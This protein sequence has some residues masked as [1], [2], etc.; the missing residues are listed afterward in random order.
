MFIQPEDEFMRN[1]LVV[2]ILMIFCITA[3]E[4]PFSSRKP[5]FPNTSQSL[6]F[7]P[8]TPEEVLTNLNYAIQE[9]NSE[10]YMRCFLNEPESQRSFRFIPDP[11]GAALYPHLVQWTWN[12]E[13]TMIQETFSLVPEDSSILLQFTENI[14]DVIAADSA[15]LVRQYHWVIHHNDPSLPRELEGQVELRMA[16]NAVG[17]WGI[18]QW[19]DNSISETP[20]FSIWKADLGAAQ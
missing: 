11:E 5:E 9:R 19:I 4:H 1:G 13:E 2:F 12:Q 18:Y 3:C 20:S 6:W 8:H 7:P 16:E 15:A 14:R 17:E 10:N